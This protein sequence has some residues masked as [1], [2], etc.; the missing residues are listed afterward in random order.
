MKII[1]QKKRGGFTL[2]ELLVVISIIG[3]LSG[4]VLVSMGGARSKARDAK[5]Q[6]DMRQISTAQEMVMGDDEQY[7]EITTNIT[8]T[9]VDQ[10]SIASAN[11]TYLTPFPKDPGAGTP[12]YKGFANTASRQQFCIWATL[13]NKGTCSATAFY[14]SSYKGTGTVCTEPATLAACGL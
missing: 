11:N 14:V 3:M 10:D 7:D 6:T 9:F 1:E 8:A 13:E 5:R 4:I 12:K 2:I